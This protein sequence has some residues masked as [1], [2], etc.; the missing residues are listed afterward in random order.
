MLS[1]C[2]YVITLERNDRKTI[3]EYEMDVNT[4]QFITKNTCSKLDVMELTVSTIKIEA[5]KIVSV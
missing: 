1:V 5:T 3:L 4:L 2:S